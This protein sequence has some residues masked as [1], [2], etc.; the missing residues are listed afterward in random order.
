MT[1]DLLPTIAKLVGAELPEHD[2]DGVDIWPL[3]AGEPGASSQQEAYYVYYRVGELQALISGRWKLYFP[4]TYRTMAGRPGGK[5]GRPTKYSQAET[6]LAL[7]DLEKDLSETTDVAAKNPEI[8]GRMQALAERAR[9][10]LGDSLV[11]R[12]GKNIRQPGRVEK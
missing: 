7:Y 3:M 10:E 4:H 9:E 12:V 2:I 8:V 1:I 11:K 5:G 6:R